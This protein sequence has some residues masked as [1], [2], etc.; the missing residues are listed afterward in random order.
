MR[1]FD[2]IALFSIILIA[3]IAGT[4]AGAPSLST[5]G[6][7]NWQYYKEITI[8]SGSALTDY[9]VL[10]KLSGS[11]FPANA[12]SDGADIRFA[13]VNGNELSYWIENWD[14]SGQSANIWVKVPS[15]PATIRIYYGNEKASSTSNGDAVFLF[16][17]D[18]D[19][20]SIN[21]AKWQIVGSHEMIVGNSLLYIG[22]GKIESTPA[23]AS[24]NYFN[25]NVIIE[26]KVKSNYDADP[27]IFAR[28]NLIAN[29]WSSPGYTFTEDPDETGWS[30]GVPSI[31]VMPAEYVIVKDPTFD[32]SPNLFYWYSA[33]LDGTKLGFRIYDTDRNK[34]VDISAIDTNYTTGTALGIGK[35]PREW[36][37]SNAWVDIFIIRKYTFAEATVT[38]GFEQPMPGSI[39]VT[40]SPSGAEVLVDGT[41]KGTA[42]PILTI[43]G[44][45][46]GSHAVKCRLSGYSDYETNTTV[47]A[48]ANA[49][50]SC[51]LSVLEAPSVD[52]VSEP[53]TIVPGETSAITVTV[54]GKDNQSI[55][56]A[57]V[58]LST[59]PGSIGK[60]RDALGRTDNNGV[61]RANFDASAEG[62]ATINTR[63]K[64]E[65]FPEAN[66]NI[67]IVIQPKEVSA[68]ITGKIIDNKTG[69]PVSNATV[70]FGNMSVT[71][72][73]DGKYELT[74]KIGE[75][76]NLTITRLGY[77][78]VKKAVTV[79]EEGTAVNFSIVSEV[80]PN[81]QISFWIILIL[82]VAGISAG[83][84]YTKSMK[85]RKKEK[86]ASG[87][88]ETLTPK[89]THVEP[90]PKKP[91]VKGKLDVK[92][93]YEY[94]C[95]K[96][97]YKVKLENNTREPIGD[98]KINLFVPKVFMLKEKE[99]SIPMLEPEES[100]TVTFEIRP[101]GE[102]GDCNVSGKIEYY[103]YNTK[104]RQMLDAGTKMVRVI[105]P[106]LKR[107]EIDIKQWE[108]A[109]EEL[110]KAEENIKELAVPAE[111]LFD[112][113]SRVIKDNSMFMLNPEISSTSKLF[114]GYARFYAHG[115]TGLRYAAYIEVVG[116]ANK[117]RLILKVWAEKEEALTGFYHRLLDEIEKRI[118]VK[119]FIDDS[120]VQHFV[121]ID[122]YV[123]RDK[124][125][126]DQ[127]GTQINDSFVKNSTIGADDR[128]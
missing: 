114:V 103:D 22:I 44:V 11:S 106:V 13:D 89:L 72:G 58:M 1:N 76:N 55:P 4:G 83:L 51:P 29:A 119:I 52:V 93:A 124:I 36:E 35:D 57:T 45:A 60:I 17:D 94:N 115:V 126:R 38:I 37:H 3:S 100:A 18:F 121:H 64:K 8:N 50:V 108:Q 102:C 47:T 5:S 42:S 84:I 90:P 97:L 39:S 104:G 56:G 23:L 43:S 24:K 120:I 82:P 67:Q 127:V 87:S 77:E 61:Y 62:T 125:G 65:N 32:A 110:I 73:Y 2:R 98:I 68:S 25:D 86:E 122:E 101:T 30:K 10:V 41:S 123:G 6:G 48:G 40:S 116:G 112:I 59:M 20:S 15:I 113:T 74:V 109:T 75:Y 27:Y 99:K 88:I 107:K 34:K 79:P 28:T 111:N 19:D 96:I 53:S 85:K 95:A 105:C 7:G 54:T 128:K 81:P 66:K 16:F 69:E 12:R 33:I 21:T 9:Q 46:P 71:T 14:K 80:P 31:G 49:T 91:E 78:T 26:M 118:D 92:S 63:V 117:S 70:S